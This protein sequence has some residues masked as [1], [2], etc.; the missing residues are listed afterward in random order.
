MP[1]ITVEQPAD[2]NRS[3]EPESPRYPTITHTRRP[4]RPANG[5]PLAALENRLWNAADELRANSGLT[6]A[7]YS[8]PVLGLIFFRYADYRFTQTK[9]E[10]TAQST[11]RRRIGKTDYQARGVLYL[12]EAARVSH[13][14]TLPESEDIG[15]SAH[16]IGAL[17]DA[18]MIL[19]SFHSVIQRWR[20]CATTRPSVPRMARGKRGARPS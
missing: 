17:L 13:L 4:A 19:I 12:P 3:T 8:V 9:Q 14:L 7:E 11:G 6:P 10:L 2:R 16:R 1:R 5:S 15:R 20:R 18:P